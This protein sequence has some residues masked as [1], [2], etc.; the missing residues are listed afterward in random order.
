[1]P[2]MLSVTSRGC[3]TERVPRSCFE[4]R[5]CTFG[6]GAANALVPCLKAGEV[7][8]KARERKAVVRKKKNLETELRALPFPPPFLPVVKKHESLYS[9]GAKELPENAV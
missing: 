2:S 6:P 4:L 7:A 5:G 9:H 8:V 3:P 1:M